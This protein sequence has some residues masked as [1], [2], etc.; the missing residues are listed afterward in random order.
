[1]QVTLPFGQMELGT[2]KPAKP[3]IDKCDYCINFCIF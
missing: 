2:K 3:N 1:M